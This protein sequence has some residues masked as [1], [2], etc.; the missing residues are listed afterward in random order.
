LPSLPSFFCLNLSRA[1]LTAF[2]FTIDVILFLRS[3]LSGNLPVTSTRSSTRQAMVRIPVHQLSF[4]EDR[5]LQ[6]M[7]DKL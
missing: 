4:E 5:E 7:D 3:R 6:A 2:F 1:E